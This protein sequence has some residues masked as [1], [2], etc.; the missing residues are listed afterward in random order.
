MFHLLLTLTDERAMQWIKG[1]FSF[2]A[3]KELEFARRDLA[4]WLFRCAHQGQ[5]ALLPIGSISVTTAVRLEVEQNQ[6]VGIF[7]EIG[8]QVNAL[9]GA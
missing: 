7:G 8:I 5:G 4:A 9:K 1:N 2:R 3:K 6:L